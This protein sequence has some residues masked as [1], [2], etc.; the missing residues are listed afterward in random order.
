MKTSELNIFS[1]ET[2]FFFFNKLTSWVVSDMGIKVVFGR[3]LDRPMVLRF[4]TA[5]VLKIIAN[6][7]DLLVKQILSELSGR[8]PCRVWTKTLST[9]AFRSDTADGFRNLQF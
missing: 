7:W 6:F 8:G 5:G 4:D 2:I 3:K 9:V 1:N